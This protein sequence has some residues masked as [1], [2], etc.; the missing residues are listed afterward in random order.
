M[1]YSLVALSRMGEKM[2]LEENAMLLLMSFSNPQLMV[3]DVRKGVPENVFEQF[4]S[5][6]KKPISP[7][8]LERLE[9]GSLPRRLYLRYSSSSAFS[10]GG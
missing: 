10:A 5:L 2:T 3:E 4:A 1:V 9:F 8:V 6:N 7:G